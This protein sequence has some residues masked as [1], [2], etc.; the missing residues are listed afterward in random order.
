[1][2]ILHLLELSAQAFRCYVHHYQCLAVPVLPGPPTINNGAQG[3]EK[4]L[5]KIQGSEDFALLL[6]SILLI[7]RS[8]DLWKITCISSLCSIHKLSF[9]SL[10][11]SFSSQYLPLLLKS[12]RSCVLFLPTPFTSVICPSMTS[13]K[14]QILVFEKDIV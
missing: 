4:L 9:V 10:T 1:M 7:R 8:V 5:I 11:S 14:W 2:Q 3:T 13:W 6:L 12:S